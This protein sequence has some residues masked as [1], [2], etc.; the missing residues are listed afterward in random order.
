MIDDRGPLDLTRR[1]DELE[2]R[3]ETMDKVLETV[4]EENTNLKII[5]SKLQNEKL[6][7]QK[8]LYDK[9]YQLNIKNYER[10]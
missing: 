6:E 1:I 7:L 2:I 4:T 5:I 10:T 3:L 9:Q 8:D